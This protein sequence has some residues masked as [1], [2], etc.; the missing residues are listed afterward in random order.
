M[1]KHKKPTQKAHESPSEINDNPLTESANASSPGSASPGRAHTDTPEED[2]SPSPILEAIRRMENSMNTRFDNLE[3]TLTGV[4]NA[5]AANTSCINTLEERHGEFDGR[6]VELEKSYGEL[7]AQNKLLK[8]KVN[9]LEGCSRRQNIKI[10]GLPEKIER[11]SPT[12]FVSDL[13]PKVLGVEHFLRVIK[14][15]CPHRI[16]PPGNQPRIMIARIHIDTVKEE[17]LR[18]TRNEGPLNYRWAVHQHLPGHH[19]R[20]DEGPQGV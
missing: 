3:T 1:V 18:V 16:G 12:A 2:A 9:N 14:V 6:L 7:Y 4:K 20:G 15:D 11:G 17:I 19:S 5:V 13:L 10:V 8:A